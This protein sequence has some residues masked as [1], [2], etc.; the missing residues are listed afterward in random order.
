M[1]FKPDPTLEA[2]K[3]DPQASK[4]LENPTALKALLSSPETQQLV[5]LLKQAAGDEL[6]GAAQAAAKGK[7][8]ALL[9]ILNHVMDSPD[10]MKTVETLT[11]KAQ[12]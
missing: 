10:G 5:S 1:M 11:K 3:Q 6:Q 7:P 4:L 8:E 2:L 9:G 12:G